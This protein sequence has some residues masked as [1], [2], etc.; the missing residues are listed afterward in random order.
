MLMSTILDL[1][2]TELQQEK[3]NKLR[4]K[5]K[6]HV[7]STAEETVECRGRFR[8]QSLKDCPRCHAAIS[9]TTICRYHPKTPVKLHGTFYFPCCGLSGKSEPEGCQSSSHHQMGFGTWNI[10]YSLPF[11]FSV[12]QS[13]IQHLE[14]FRIHETNELNILIR[15]I[16]F[17]YQKVVLGITCRYEYTEAASALYQYRYLFYQIHHSDV[18]DLMN[19]G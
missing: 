17:I 16:D 3:D 4:L 6:L 15:I 11:L 19:Q 18:T 13:S 9:A 5:R 14:W 1:R 2:N 7:L 10:R 8:R 12:S